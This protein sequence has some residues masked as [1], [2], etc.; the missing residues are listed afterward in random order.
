MNGERRMLITIRRRKVRWSRHIFR[1]KWQL[2][3]V[4]ERKLEE[5]LSWNKTNPLDRR[6]KAEKKFWT[7][8]EEATIGGDGKRNFHNNLLLDR[9][10]N[11]S[12]DDNNNIFNLQNIFIK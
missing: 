4:T 2:H 5:T 11:N 7:L 8:R 10:L 12:N 1:R 9:A 6:F 3:D